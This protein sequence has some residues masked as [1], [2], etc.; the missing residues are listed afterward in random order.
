MV[1]EVMCTVAKSFNERVLTMAAKP[2]LEKRVD[3]LEEKLEQLVQVQS[4]RKVRRILVSAPGV[5][6]LT[7]TIEK[8][9]KEVPFDSAKCERA[10][11]YFYQSECRGI[12]CSALNRNYYQNYRQRLKGDVEHDPKYGKPTTRKR[13]PAKK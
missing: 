12:A 11:I 1:S 5:C 4:K 6:G 9:G 2:S 7:P 13:K 10:S 3:Q 8:N